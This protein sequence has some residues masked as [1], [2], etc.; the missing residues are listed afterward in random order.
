[1]SLRTLRLVLILNK[2]KL[3][4]VPTFKVACTKLS[5]LLVLLNRGYEDT[6]LYEFL[7]N[8]PQAPFFH[9]EFGIPDNHHV[10]YSELRQLFNDPNYLKFAFVR[11]PYKR[12]ESIYHYRIRNPAGQIN[13]FPQEYAIYLQQ[14]SIDFVKK[15]KA[16]L[17]WD[18][19]NLSK[20]ISKEINTQTKL[21]LLFFKE[22]SFLLGARD[23]YFS[24]ETLI[25]TSGKYNY[26]LLLQKIVEDYRDFYGREGSDSIYEQLARRIQSFLGYPQLEEINLKQNPVSFEEFIN[27]ICEQHIKC[28]DPHWMPQKLVL[29][30]DFIKYDFIGRI[31]S[32]EQDIHYL[33]NKIQAPKYIYQYIGGKMN[34]S[35]KIGRTSLWTDELAEKVYEKYKSDFAAFGYE[36]MSYKN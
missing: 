30:Y 14:Y 9:W 18:A 28:M 25:Q 4:Y 1:M 19:P 13:L 20:K 35:Q 6:E 11:N 7:Q 10:T 3:L 5:T 12:L 23:S 17:I 8:T 27:F 24:N 36:Q 26:N 22:L 32:F 31:E 21:I 34:D 2:Y 16:Q 33:F 29:G 15:I